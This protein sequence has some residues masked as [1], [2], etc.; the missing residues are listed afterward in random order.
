MVLNMV[1]MEFSVLPRAC[2]WGGAE[3][4]LEKDVNANVSERNAAAA[5]HQLALYHQEGQN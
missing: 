5:P 2:L 1:E 3:D 4:H